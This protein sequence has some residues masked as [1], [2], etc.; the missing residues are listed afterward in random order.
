MAGEYHQGAG[1]L[2]LQTVNP[3]RNRY[4]EDFYILCLDFNPPEFMSN[5][6]E[7]IDGALA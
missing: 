4:E 2:I 3:Y 6:G 5:L 1:M 7:S